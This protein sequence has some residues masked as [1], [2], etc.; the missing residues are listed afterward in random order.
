MPALVNKLQACCGVGR[1]H[2]YCHPSDHGG[3]PGHPVIWNA[4][5]FRKH[6]TVEPST[7]GPASDGHM[8]HQHERCSANHLG[9][10]FLT[11][12]SN[13][14]SHN[15]GKPISPDVAELLIN[16][17]RAFLR[18]LTRHMGS[19]D[20]A[21][22]VLQQFYLRAIS[23]ASDIK[24]R[25][26]VLQWLYRVLSSTLAD[27]YRAKTAR[28]RSEAQYAY[29]Q[30]K[31][32]K[33]DV[34]SEAACMCFYQLLPTLKPEYSEMLQR[35]DLSGESRAKVAEDLDITLN[36]V[37]VR[38]HR[39]RQALKHALLASCKGCCPEH[40]FMNCECEHWERMPH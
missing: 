25:E 8:G 7:P 11:V 37:R 23:K 6:G 26:S 34:D 40:N 32:L 12:S 3:D 16:N 2:L 27:Y 35:V 24:K 1:R 31:S 19:T 17:R 15:S 4:P 10:D 36:L 9:K 13:P 5:P 18:F 30:P 20:M 28:Q 22:E 39:A 38:L 33:D 21:E 29:F 14:E